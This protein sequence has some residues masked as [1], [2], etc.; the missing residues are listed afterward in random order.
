METHCTVTPPIYES[1]PSP[2]ILQISSPFTAA[3]M[4]LVNSSK[5]FVHQTPT[6]TTRVIHSMR[7]ASIQCCIKVG[8]YSI[9]T[10]HTNVG[11]P[12]LVNELFVRAQYTPFSTKPVHLPKNISQVH[13]RVRRKK[14]FF[15][16][17]F[18]S[19]LIQLFGYKS[20]LWSMT[21]L[22]N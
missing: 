2:F 8:I 17:H 9:Y 10:P 20:S 19:M 11:T 22:C 16:P 7:F 6:C 3:P 18:H 5:L 1:T 13:T 4:L 21:S 15:P 14:N 12:S